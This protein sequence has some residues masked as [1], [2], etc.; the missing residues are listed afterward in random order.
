MAKLYIV[1]TPIG[2]LE[3][4]SLRAL[5]VLGEVKT[6]LCE[7]TRVSSKLLNYFEIKD[8]K[9][10]SC[11][12]HNE[13]TRVNEII[14]LLDSGEDLALVSDAG[15]PLISDP[16]S[17]IIKEIF[18][19]GH[20]IIPLA[21]ASALTTALSACPI[22]VSR[23]SFHGFL[24]HSGQHRRRVLK[25]IKASDNDLTLVFYE[26]PHRIIK[27]L[28]DMQTI[29]DSE[30]EQSQV[31]LARELT[32]KFEQFY[33]GSAADIINQ[34]SEQF[35]LNKKSAKVQGEFVVVLKHCTA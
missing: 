2:N 17:I 20:E 18:S 7:D 19:S 3:D 32:K 13:A 6:I 26:S 8:K 34:L 28:K 33:F 10:I 29:F 16:G 22:D 30:E 25:Q 24:P 35:D 15:T 11:H 14:K 4:I 9:L 12:E 21:G 23:F 31:F 27:T 1:A 5:K